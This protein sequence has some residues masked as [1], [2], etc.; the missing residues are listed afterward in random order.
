MLRGAGAGQTRMI[1]D[2]LD[3]NMTL[4]LDSAFGVAPDH[5]SDIVVWG[6]CVHQVVMRDNTFF[7]IKKHVEQEA[8]TATVM[9]PL[10]GRAHRATYSNNVGRDMRVTMYSMVNGQD[11]S[12]GGSLSVT[13]HIV[14][15]VVSTHTRTGLD[16]QPSPHNDRL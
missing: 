7:G 9:I 6:S 14:R 3:D 10:W 15:D 5:D 4:V 16:I 2:L 1:A 12:N 11:V 8:H 13:D